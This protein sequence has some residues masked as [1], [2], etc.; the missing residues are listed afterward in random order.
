MNLCL[1]SFTDFRWKYVHNFK[2]PC[3]ADSREMSLWW[4][5]CPVNGS[6]PPFLQQ[7]VALG[8]VLAAKE[9]TVSRQWGGVNRLQHM[10]LLLHR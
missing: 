7:P 9:T 6:L 3:E 8:E 4:Q 1:H 2:P 10:M 5:L